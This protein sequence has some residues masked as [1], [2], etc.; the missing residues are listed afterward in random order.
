MQS[1]A[2]AADWVTI[3]KVE[4]KK[5]PTTYSIA[6]R[7]IANG[8]TIYYRIVAVDR[9]G[10]MDNSNTVSVSRNALGKAAAPSF[11]LVP[12]PASNQFTVRLSD[13][14]TYAQEAI[15]ILDLQGRFVLKV[16]PQIGAYSIAGLAPGAYLVSVPNGKQLPLIVSRER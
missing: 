10:E 4:A 13:G 1:N 2:G 14:S 9:A 11:S 5:V 16:S 15:S 3:A 7:A 6:D 8:R 12:N